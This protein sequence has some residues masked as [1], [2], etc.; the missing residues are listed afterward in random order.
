MARRPGP[1]PK[2]PEDRKHRN[3]DPVVG[4]EGWTEIPDEPFDGDIPPIPAWI[5]V[6]EPVV[7]AYET[8]GSL[9]QARTW[10]AGDWLSLHLALPTI[11]RFLTGSR[12]K[13]S[14]EAFKALISTLG[15]ALSLNSNDMLKAR[16]RFEQAEAEEG[17]GKDPNAPLPE[18][19][20]RMNDR[21]KRL[22]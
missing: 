10:N 21:R 6:S 18:N 16:I 5:D 1:A 2:F 17:E 9:P 14:S 8:I 15:P 7:Q 13:G 20:A 4:N 12:G 11:D 3:I 22:G 19:V